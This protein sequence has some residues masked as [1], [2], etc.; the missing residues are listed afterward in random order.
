M[1]DTP[2]G[3]QLVPPA[4]W[5]LLASDVID[6]D[7]AT[8]NR[9]WVDSTG[10]DS[11]SGTWFYHV[12]AHNSRCP[13]EGAVPTGVAPGASPTGRPVRVGQ[14]STTPRNVPVDAD[15]ER[16]PAPASSA[17]GDL[18]RLYHFACSVGRFLSLAPTYARSA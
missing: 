9:Q 2:Q 3:S 17:G 5:P 12:T 10:D 15:R 11:P 7:E 8:P 16:S 4:L 1:T 13:A 14:L 18:W 6:M